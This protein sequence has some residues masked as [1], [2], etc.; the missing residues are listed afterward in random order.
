M[1]SWHSSSV[2]QCFRELN[3]NAK[4]LS[5]QEAE[6]RLTVFGKNELKESPKEPAW[7]QFLAQFKSAVVLILIGAA[8]ISGFLGEWIDTIVIVALVLLNAILGFLQEYKAE[9]AMHALKKLSAPKARVLRDDEWNLIDANQLVV[10]DVV[11]LE[12]G[13]IVPADCRIIESINLRASEASLTGES[14]P[15]GKIAEKVSESAGVADRKN[16]CFMNTVISFGRGKA[17]VVES[18]MRTEFG[19]IAQ[20]LQEMEVEE[21]PLAKKLDALG[22]QLG[23]YILAL[24]VVLFLLMAFIGSEPLDEA[25]L[26][27]VSL[28]VAAIPE[29]LP[30]IVAITLALGMKEMAKKNALVRKMA[31][32]E[33]L[34]ETTVIC[35][36]KTGTL[37]RNEMTVTLLWADGKTFS[38]SGSGYNTE[39]EIAREGKKVFLEKKRSLALL[40]KCGVLCNNSTLGVQQLGDPTE[41]A[42]LV[43]GKKAGLEKLEQGES[44]VSEAPFDSQRKRMSV[45]FEVGK[46]QTVWTK[47]AV[48]KVLEC[49]THYLE[50]GKPKLLNASAKEKILAENNTMAASGLRVL[51]FAT[52]T[53]S[54]K[55]YTVEKLEK[56]LSFIGLCGMIDTPRAECKPAIALCKSAGIRVKMITGDHPLTA[57][58][59]AVQL[60]LI[61][62]KDSVLSGTELDA[63]SDSELRQQVQDVHVFARVNP[64]HKLRIVQ[65]LKANGEVVAVTGDGVNDALA[66]KKADIGV[67]MGI[68]GTDVAKEAS[69]MVIEDDNFATIVNAVR[70]GRRVY[71]NIRNFVRYLLA[72]N[73]G[74]VAILSLV[75]LLDFFLAKNL[76][77]PLLPIQLL[78]LNLVTDGLPALALGKEKLEE[79]VM[80]SPPRN[81]KFGILHG[82]GAFIAITG[83]ISTAA[84]LA[85]YFVGLET[86]SPHAQTM[87][88]STLIFFELVLVFGLRSE[89]KGVFEMNLFSNPSLL[90]AVAS[91]IILTLAV[92]LVPSL[93]SLFKIVPLDAVQWTIVL[94]LSLVAILVPYTVR[95]VKR[96]GI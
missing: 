19:K 45:V 34:G 52:K 91:S 54:E 95:L 60:G 18:G 11:S 82:M 27:A 38:V 31:A 96:A 26:T 58:A 53:F 7:K 21:T 44:F 10:G 62:E 70:E 40:L 79:E 93:Q 73:V 29:G 13:N 75:V 48:E 22:K 67:A 84:V 71:A 63:L 43:L 15:V 87:A 30:A 74:E 77:I 57:K 2:E 42:L 90:L 23:T 12:E 25:L 5:S 88:F 3:A 37:T 28:A 89:K 72:A 83:I 41:L 76:P 49:C 24:C 4:G 33:A 50:N 94:G 6:K 39:G 61:G 56:N 47:G 59:V 81:P 86:S 32:V 35:S 36:D 68:T 1:V 9:Q 8:I 46:K 55:S 66:L 69:Q 80:Q 65:A 85:A 92:L 16:M 64:E 14:N 78:W 20:S 51:G 17:I